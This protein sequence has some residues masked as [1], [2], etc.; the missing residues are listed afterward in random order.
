MS[1][2]EAVTAGVKSCKKCGGTAFYADRSCK[3]CKKE[4]GKKWADMHR[5]KI[6]EFNAKW[7]KENPDK[8]KKCVHNWREK[9]KEKYYSSMAEYRN[10]HKKQRADTMLKWRLLNLDKIRDYFKKWTIKNPNA[11]RIKCSNRRKMIGKGTLSKDIVEKLIFLQKGKC[12]CCGEAIN[13]NY[14]LDHKMPIALGGAN[15]D[16]NMQ[17]LTSKCNLKKG[18]KHPIEYMQSKGYLL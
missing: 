9:N 16:W 14:H 11:N 3:S 1:A 7:R 4:Y 13:N 5:E 17:L 6:K 10:T 15:E 12:A 2:I 8:L 18:K